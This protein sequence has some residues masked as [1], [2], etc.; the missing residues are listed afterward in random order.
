MTDTLYIRTIYLVRCA[1]RSSILSQR[2]RQVFILVE[3]PFLD[4]QMNMYLHKLLHVNQQVR[5]FF[6]SLFESAFISD[7]S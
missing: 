5:T 2:C 3:Y 7:E 1:Y 6:Y 4:Y